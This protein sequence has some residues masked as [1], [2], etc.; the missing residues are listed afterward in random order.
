MRITQF[1]HEKKTCFLAFLHGLF[2]S[3]YNAS[4]ESVLKKTVKTEYSVKMSLI[5]LEIK[6]N[7]FSMY[8]N[9]SKLES[10]C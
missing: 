5:D 9:T 4:E 1:L 6:E 10:L 8:K 7:V 2:H 3:Q